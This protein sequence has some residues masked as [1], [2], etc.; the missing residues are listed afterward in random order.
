MTRKD[1][2]V[3]VAEIL[4]KTFEVSYEDIKP[5]TRLQEDL[6]LDSIDAVDLIVKLQAQTDKKIDP[7][8]FRQVRTIDDVVSVIYK[9]VSEAP[10]EK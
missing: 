3:Q 1:I 4:N 2:E 8:S 7:E 5:E 6:D 9:L 10:A